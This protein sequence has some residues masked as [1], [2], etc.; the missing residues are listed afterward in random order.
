MAKAAGRG[1]RVLYGIADLSDL[2]SNA[3]IP[4]EV[5]AL[6]VTGLGDTDRKY[7]VGLRAGTVSLSGF[8]DGAVDKIDEEVSAS[9]ASANGEVVT[10]AP[11]GLTIGNKA[12]VLKARST[13]FAVG[14][15]VDGVVS[16]SLD[17]QADN[18]IRTGHIL[19]ALTAETATGQSASVDNGAATT[20][21]GVAHLHATSVSQ[22]TSGT[23]TVII[24]QSTT[25]AFAGEETTLATF[26]IITGNTAVAE[27][28]TVTGTSARYL[29]AKWTQAGVG[30][31]WTFAVAYGRR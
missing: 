19:H 10:V 24:Q 31:T 1:C 26:T 29:R 11:E 18:G 21:G 5:A 3:D 17:I 13:R 25:N 8:W 12:K 15:P 4:E 6:E 14:T 28:V 30:G 2:F 23:L 20:V 16:A 7:I 27:T 9:L 22:G